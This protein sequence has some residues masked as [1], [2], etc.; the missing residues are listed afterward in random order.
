[1]SY[2]ASGPD[3]VRALASYVDR[4]LRGATPAELPLERMATY[5]LGINL[6]TAAAL[7]VE[8]PPHLRLL[9]AEVFE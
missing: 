2:G 8:V 4:I 9:A 7:G 6:A 5:L 1:M 3:G